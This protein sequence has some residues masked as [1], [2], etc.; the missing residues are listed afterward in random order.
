[1]LQEAI[2]EE[3]GWLYRGVFIAK[4]KGGFSFTVLSADNN[5]K[6]ANWF[7]PY[8]NTLKVMKSEVDNYLNAGCTVE[9]RKIK[10]I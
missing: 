6:G 1:M 4:Q 8:P 7:R 10:K 5:L 3:A 9:N 2:K